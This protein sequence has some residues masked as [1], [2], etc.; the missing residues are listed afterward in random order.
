MHVM[1][2][3][4][5]TED[6]FVH[7]AMDAT[8]SCKN[9]YIICS[10]PNIKSCSFKYHIFKHTFSNLLSDICKA[11][12]LSKSY[13]SHC[14]RATAIQCLTL[15]N[16]GYKPKCI[17]YMSSHRNKSSFNSE[18]HFL[19]TLVELEGEQVF[20]LLAFRARPLI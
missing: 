16:L 4:D 20:T 14:L 3:Y 10:H 1:H 19:N 5:I 7:T 15:S 9:T 11:A 8:A 12:S 17:M 13:T 6:Q 18:Y 2:L